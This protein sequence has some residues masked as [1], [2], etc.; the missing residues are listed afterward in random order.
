MV[1]WP[2]VLTTIIVLKIAWSFLISLATIRYSR[3]TLLYGVSW[4]VI[5]YNHHHPKISVHV[6]L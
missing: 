2:A 5:V 3:R 1:S 4:L 6:V